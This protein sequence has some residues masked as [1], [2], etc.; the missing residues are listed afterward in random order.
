MKNRRGSDR[1]RSIG[2]FLNGGN[3]VGRFVEKDERVEMQF[4]YQPDS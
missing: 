4:F 1:Q 3:K 2:S